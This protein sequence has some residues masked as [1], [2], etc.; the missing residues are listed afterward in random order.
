[1][2]KLCSRLVTTSA[3][4]AFS[5]VTA[6]GAAGA[7]AAQDA[8]SA[9]IPNHIHEGACANLGAVVAP[10][11]DLSFAAEGATGS[12][13]AEAMSTPMATPVSLTDAAS[14]VS[15][16]DAASPVAGM[17][18]SALPV[19]VATTSVPLALDQILA[20]Q[21]AINLHD[22]AAPGDASRYLA[23]GD[24]AGTPDEQGNLFVGLAEDNDSGFS[25]V[26]WLLDGGDG[27]S[28]TVTV[29]LSEGT[30]GGM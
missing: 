22:P 5:A 16:A 19:A 20:T 6:V 12:P 25:G 26:A 4:L 28:T 27:A 3:A 18:G 23:C 29:F 7:V 10:L 17:L 13:V 8:M 15:G 11:A 14:P 2:V 9:P 30:T 24:L 21:H 1:M